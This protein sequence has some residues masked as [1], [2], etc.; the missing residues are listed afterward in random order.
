MR[1][2]VARKKKPLAFGQRLLRENSTAFKK[3]DKPN[4]PQNGL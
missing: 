4:E 3:M 2:W 1:G